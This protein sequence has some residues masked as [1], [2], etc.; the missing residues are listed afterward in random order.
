MPRRCT[1]Y[2][3]QLGATAHITKC[4]LEVHKHAF[5]KLA[6]NTIHKSGILSYHFIICTHIRLLIRHRIIH[7]RIEPTQRIYTYDVWLIVYV[8]WIDALNIWNAVTYAQMPKAH[9]CIHLLELHHYHAISLV[10]MSSRAILPK[11]QWIYSNL[12]LNC[13]IIESSCN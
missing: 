8:C 1:S 11:T 2:H 10:S 13:I 7:T 5:L 4:D 6:Q 3:H 9:I 12:F